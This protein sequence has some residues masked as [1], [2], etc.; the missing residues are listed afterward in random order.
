MKVTPR[1]VYRFNRAFIRGSLSVLALRRYLPFPV[2]VLPL[3]VVCWFLWS[4]LKVGLAP[5]H[6]PDFRVVTV[7]GRSTISYFA[8]FAKNLE[9]PWRRRREMA[10]LLT[11]LSASESMA[12][13]SCNICFEVFVDGSV[14]HCGLL[15]CGHNL[16]F[17]CFRRLE[18]QR[19]PWCRKYTMRDLTL[20]PRRLADDDGNGHLQPAPRTFDDDLAAYVRR[21]NRLRARRPAQTRLWNW[22]RSCVGSWLDRGAPS[23]SSPPSPRS[24]PSPGRIRNRRRL[25]DLD[26]VRPRVG[27][28]VILTSSVE[29]AKHVVEL[30]RTRGLGDAH[31]YLT[32]SDLLLNN[33]TDLMG[34]NFRALTVIVRSLLP[35]LQ[36]IQE[37]ARDVTP[38]RLLVTQGNHDDIACMLAQCLSVEHL[39]VLDYDGHLRRA[40]TDDGPLIRGAFTPYAS[41]LLTV[42]RLRETT[43]TD[44]WP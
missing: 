30:L 33:Y 42:A 23:S 32:E 25:Q 20:R 18:G 24:C 34:M 1:V 41:G 43:S 29:A 27:R 38:L 14:N 26:Y 4:L 36:G 9:D 19:C 37:V 35:H 22:V 39:L 40:P 3:S 2:Y 17:L 12:E 6:P 15:P 28:I 21:W 16:C 7:G 44:P 11:S 10:E 13:E 31:A 8:Q 5:S